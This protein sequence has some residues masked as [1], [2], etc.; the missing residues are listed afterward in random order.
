VIEVDGLTTGD[1]LAWARVALDAIEQAHRRLAEDTASSRR[2]ALVGFDHAVEA[3]VAGYLNDGPGASDDTAEATKARPRK[4][5]FWD[6]SSYVVARAHAE[7]VMYEVSLDALNVVRSLRNDIQHGSAW[8][9]PS[10]ETVEVA[11]RAALDLLR[12]FGVTELNERFG[13][14]GSTQPAYP[15]A[16]TI[17]DV[18]TIRLPKSLGEAAWIVAKLVDPRSDGVHVSYLTDRLIER[19]F[20]FS[21]RAPEASVYDSIRREKKRFDVVAPMV[22][23]W[24]ESGEAEERSEISAGILAEAAYAYAKQ[25]DPLRHGMHYYR[26]YD[27]MLRWRIPIK[28]ADAA[29][30]LRRAVASSGRFDRVAP[31]TYVWK[32]DDLGTSDPRT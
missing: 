23:R 21:G 9:V 4:S 18:E 31:A 28:G 2:L 17:G 1:P 15:F 20:K 7:G 10:D 16:V 5:N 24:K 13:A 11:R 12:V 30:T 14:S 29:A 8:V 6:R 19:G 22:Y 25:V 32:L 27:G 3:G 26:L